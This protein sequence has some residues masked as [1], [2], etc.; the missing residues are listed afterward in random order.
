MAFRL[1]HADFL[2]PTDLVNEGTNAIFNADTIQ[3]KIF[4]ND[5][6]NKLAIGYSRDDWARIFEF[7]IGCESYKDIKN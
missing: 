4:E 1:F 5:Y 6:K 3:D 7:L 2:S